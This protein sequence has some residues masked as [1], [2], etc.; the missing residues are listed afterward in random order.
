VL[1]SE[2]CADVLALNVVGCPNLDNTC[3]VPKYHPHVVSSQC[4]VL[5]SSSYSIAQ[6]SWPGKLI[7]LFVISTNYG[8]LMTY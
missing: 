1:K 2:P 7:P 6:H 8:V 3:T 5:I 4:F